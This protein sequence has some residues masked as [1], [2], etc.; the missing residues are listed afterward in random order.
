LNQQFTYKGFVHEYAVVLQS[1]LVFARLLYFQSNM[2]R[3]PLFLFFGFL[4][5]MLVPTGCTS[6]RKA[7][8][9]P[10][11]PS[12][13]DLLISGKRVF[14]FYARGEQP[15]IDQTQLTEIIAALRETHPDKAG[16][17]EKGYADVAAAPQSSVKGIA[18]R[19]ITQLGDIGD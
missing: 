12:S 13:T 3:I 6:K 11:L 4:C 2:Q 17:L 10:P 14:E 8:T 1:Q 19:V 7:E 18:L 16:I 5:L 15:D 9:T